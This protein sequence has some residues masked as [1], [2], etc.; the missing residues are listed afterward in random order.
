[1]SPVGGR[2]GGRGPRRRGR[3]SAVRGCPAPRRSRTRCRSRG[4]SWGLAGP[5][6]G[7]CIAFARLVQEFRRTRPK[8]ERRMSS[9]LEPV[10]ERPRPWS[11]S[12]PAPARNR[13]LRDGLARADE[14]VGPRGRPQDHRQGGA[15]GSH[16]RSERPRRR[17]GC[18]IP[19]ACAHTASRRT[20]STSTSRTSTCRASHCDRRSAPASSATRAPS[21]RRPGSRGARLR[22]RARHRPSRRQAVER[23][24]RGG[25]RGLGAPLRL[26]ARAAGGRRDADR[27]RRRP[28]HAG[29][30]LARAPARR[31]AGPPADVW[32]VGVLL[33]EALSGHHPFWRASPLETGEEIKSGRRRSRG[34]ARST[35]RG[36]WPQSTRALAV[37]PG[38]RRPRLARPGASDAW[39]AR[40]PRRARERPR[41]PARIEP[42]RVA[43]AES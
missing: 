15:S 39:S 27:G 37:E 34:A 22:A 17:P 40:A 31:A 2:T 26:R 42:R 7:H 32:A 8:P 23:A 9:A 21:R 28:G 1:M 11:L 3:S 6:P 38:A 4:R 5:E 35:G 30:H 43:A 29:L 16:E 33:W 25:G 20:T 18:A 19:T 14:N 24:R 41:L 36:S 13:R 10:P 12:A